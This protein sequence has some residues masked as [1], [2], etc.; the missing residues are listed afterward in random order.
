MP[1]EI[2]AEDLA[3]RIRAGEPL[4]LV[5]VREDWEREIAQI[6]GDVHIPMRSVPERLADFAAPEGGQIVIYCHAGVRSMMVAGFLEQN[7]VPSVSSLAG[8][9]DAWSTT[10]DPTVPRY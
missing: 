8:G 5:D 9:I 2:T 10:V 7:G 1:H 3:S 6:P 4:L